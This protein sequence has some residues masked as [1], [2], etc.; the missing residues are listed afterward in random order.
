MAINQLLQ[1][2]GEDDQV[3]VPPEGR[4]IYSDRLVTVNAVG[5]VPWNVF[6]LHRLSTLQRAG[7]HSFRAREKV[8][9]EVL[10]SR[11]G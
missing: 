9:I 8:V 7:H 4:R 6:A 3:V 10:S 11:A 2:D 5:D 1:K